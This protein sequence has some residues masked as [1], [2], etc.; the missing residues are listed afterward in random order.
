MT[1][2][3]L[4]E[5]EAYDSDLFTRCERMAP[6]ERLLAPVHRS[7]AA[8][9]GMRRSAE[10]RRGGRPTPNKRGGLYQ[11][12]NCKSIW[13]STSPSQFTRREVNP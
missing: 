2:S 1:S 13:H 6:R 10:L 11:R 3:T 7:Q 12:R 9:R 5:W 8:I 4:A